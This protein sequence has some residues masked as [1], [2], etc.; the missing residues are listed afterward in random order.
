MIYVN[1]SFCSLILLDSGELSIYTNTSPLNNESFTYFPSLCFYLLFLL[2]KAR[3]SC[4]I[5]NENGESR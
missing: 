2:I 5:V 3:T 1:L 4:T